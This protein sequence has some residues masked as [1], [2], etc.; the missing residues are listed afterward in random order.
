MLNGKYTIR[1]DNIEVSIFNWLY[2][3]LLIYSLIISLLHVVK[4]DHI[5]LHVYSQVPWI[6]LTHH[7]ANFTSSSSSFSLTHQLQLVLPTCGR[8]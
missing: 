2:F 6:P 7:S 8:V 3:I 4:C 1:R 5:H